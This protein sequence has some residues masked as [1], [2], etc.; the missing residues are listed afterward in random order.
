MTRKNCLVKADPVLAQTVGPVEPVCEVLEETPASAIGSLRGSPQV[1]LTLGSHSLSLRERRGGSKP[2]RDSQLWALPCHSPPVISHFLQRLPRGLS[3]LLISSGGRGL[4]GSAC[5]REH[6]RATL[7]KIP[8]SCYSHLI[9]SI[10][11]ESSPL[12]PF[13]RM[14]DKIL[15]H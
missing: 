13:T 8:S 1:L 12:P 14:K 10:Q 15:Y 9:S 3:I 6:L 11:H 4:E 2:V 5:F 7:L